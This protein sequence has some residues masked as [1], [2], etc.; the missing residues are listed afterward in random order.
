MLK[1]IAGI[2]LIILGIIDGWKYVVQA[3]K[4]RHIGLAKGQS[5]M[6]INLAW[7]VDLGKI[8]CGCIV[9]EQWLVITTFIGF[10]CTMYLFFITYQYYPFR[11]RG[12]TNFKKPNL[13]I[14]TL[15]SWLPNRLRRRL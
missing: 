10:I 11:M 7:G 12:C 14:Y 3:E 9:L 2:V 6:F 5:R 15:N 4:I 1:I 13:F 8:I